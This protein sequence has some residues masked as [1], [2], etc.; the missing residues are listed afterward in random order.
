MKF[1]GK[2]GFIEANIEVAPDV[3]RDGVVE[4]S[5]V[6]DVIRNRRMNTPSQYQN[7]S[8]SVSNSISILS[9]LYARQNWDSIRY[10]IWNGKKLSV[11]NVEI[12]FPRIT[13]EIGGI[14]NGKNPVRIEGTPRSN[15]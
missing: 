13:L 14:Y 8:F 4:R 2:V 5:Y 1:V 12:D 9:D 6:G 10:A 15:L 11:S 3:F 7:D